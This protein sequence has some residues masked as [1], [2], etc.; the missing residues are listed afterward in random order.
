MSHPKD[1]Q[2]EICNKEVTRV[3]VRLKIRQGLLA[4]PLLRF[5]RTYI[6]NGTS[7]RHTHQRDRRCFA[8]EMESTRRTFLSNSP[9]TPQPSPFRTR[10]ALSILTVRALAL[11]SYC[12]RRS[13]RNGEDR[14]TS[15]AAESPPSFAPRFSP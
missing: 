7:R 6:D 5:L 12:M 10:P 11:L 1:F 8:I 4:S 2:T 15:G 13:K 3:K 14:S 9:V